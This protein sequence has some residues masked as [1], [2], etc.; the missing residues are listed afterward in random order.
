MVYNGKP[1]QN[2]WFGG[3]TIFGNTHIGWWLQRFVFSPRFFFGNDPI[4][5]EHIFSKWVGE[6]PPT[7]KCFVVFY[8]GKTVD[9][10]EIRRSPVD[11]VKRAHYLYIFFLNT[12]QVVGRTGFL[13]YNVRFHPACHFFH[14]VMSLSRIWAINICLSK[15]SSGSGQM[16]SR[17]KTRP[18]PQGWW[19]LMIW[20]ERSTDFPILNDPREGMRNKVR[21]LRTN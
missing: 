20:P 12:S 14:F 13:P 21:V 15:M 2:G 18:G 1:F 4:W 9:G 6:K 8:H 5:R 11:R 17:P 3:T 7:S 10:S 19:S 16:S